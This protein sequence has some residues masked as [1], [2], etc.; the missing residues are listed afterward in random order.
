MAISRQ[1][2]ISLLTSDHLIIYPSHIY[3]SLLHPSIDYLHQPNKISLPLF[4]SLYHTKQCQLA[5]FTHIPATSISNEYVII[6]KLY[7]QNNRHN[8]LLLG[9][10]LAF[11]RCHLLLKETIQRSFIKLLI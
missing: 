9:P 5:M 1:K 8:D 4:F 2:G 11:I 3:K 6:L 10:C 7:A